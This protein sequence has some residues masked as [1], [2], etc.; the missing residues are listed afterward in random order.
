MVPALSEVMAKWGRKA[1]RR[2]VEGSAVRAM[3][4]SGTGKF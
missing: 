4:E 3:E 1:S 2:Q